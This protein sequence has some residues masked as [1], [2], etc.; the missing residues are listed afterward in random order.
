MDL[1]QN[2]ALGFSVS[3]TPENLLV[4]LVGTALG[5]A[6]GVLPGLGPTATISLLLPIS[7]AIDHVSAVILLAGIY[8]GAMYGG[9]ITSILVRIPGEAASVITCIDG[10]AM[11]RRGRA[12]AAL[13]IAAFGSF[14]AGVVA[15]VGVALV[16]PQLATYALAFGPAERAAL[17]LFGLV[18]VANVGDGS[19]RRAYAMLA[20]GLLLST[21]G[22]DLV[23]GVE[24]FTFGVPYLRDGFGIAVMAMGLFGISEV[25]M[26]A[27]SPDVDMRPAAYGKRLADLLPDRRDW[28][29]SAG[30]IGRGT[31]IGFFLGLLPGGG[32]L[33]SSFASYV[34]EKRLSRHPEQF[35][36]GAIA[37][38]AGPE[39]ANNAAAQ[40][41][42]V[43]LLC[44]GIPAN[45]V[46]GVIMGA[47]LM[48][49]V[50]P[51]PRLIVDQPAVFWGVVTSMLI[52]NLML[53]VLNVPLV[54][55][56]VALLRVPQGIM[57]PLIVLFCGVGAYSL[58]NSVAD[59]Y[60]MVGFGFLGYGLRR[61]GFDPAPLLLAFVLGT[62]LEQNLRQALL[63]GY[64]S[65][66]IFLEKPIAATFIA[67][68]V[69]AAVLP[70]LR[71]RM[72]RA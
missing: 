4:A 11:A 7:V 19:R 2:L 5:T 18:L 46:I 36:K 52:G 49:G 43:P 72:V 34:V 54:G 42:F 67:M 17:V 23:S 8:Y 20:A 39:S 70:L 21:V 48:H 71:G 64:G 47:L 10:Y 27:A 28:K 16:G 58:N 59:V 26:L 61:A 60:A 41:S 62:L 68:T 30:P 22:I 6:V 35:G 63:I 33:I 69:T 57:S 15:T 65:P 13:G 32:A 44:L 55:A 53:I 31:A 56:F 40:S 9:S 51:G 29:E 66:V 12:G 24:R 50:T 45:A 1:W 14:I 25:L 3:L 37:G 38:V